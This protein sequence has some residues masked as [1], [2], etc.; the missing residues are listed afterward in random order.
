[1]TPYTIDNR[2][3][4]VEILLLKNG[5]KPLASQR[6]TIQ[7]LGESEDVDATLEEIQRESEASSFVD[8]LGLTR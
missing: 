5:Q 3:E 1:M 6:E 8:A 2:K 7:A 4:E